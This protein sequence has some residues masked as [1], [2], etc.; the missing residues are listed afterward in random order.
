[1]LT[2]LINNL[3]WAI[4]YNA[5]E[6]NDRYALGLKVGSD[7]SLNFRMPFRKFDFI[8]TDVHSLGDGVEFSATYNTYLKP[9]KDFDPYVG[10]GIHIDSE[11]S[12]GLRLPVG[13]NY[14]LEDRPALLYTEISGD[15]NDKGVN[16]NFHVGANYLF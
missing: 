5:N 4:D 14:K 15:I 2:F 10:A 12:S 13:L 11:G 6:Y 3:S 9:W 7:S 16:V 8:Q 1:M